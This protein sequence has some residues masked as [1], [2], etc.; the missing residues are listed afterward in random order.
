MIHHQRLKDEFFSS[1]EAAKPRN[2]DAQGSSKGNGTTESTSKPNPKPKLQLKKKKV[3][4]DPFA[5]DDDEEEEPKGKTTN[6]LSKATSKPL[7]KASSKPLSKQGGPARELPSNT[8]MKRV[9]EESESDEEVK[10]K[11]KRRALMKSKE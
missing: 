11:P 1:L 3:D 10:A 7:S 8:M 4:D 5:T 6:P 9:R 2:D